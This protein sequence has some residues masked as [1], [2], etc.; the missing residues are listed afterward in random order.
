MTA[1]LS[2][3][4]RFWPHL[5]AFA[6]GAWVAAAVQEIRIE[7]LQDRHTAYVNQQEAL[8]LESAKAALL[9]EKAWIKEKEDAQNAAAQREASL[10]AELSRTR[11]AAD[12]LRDTANAI[13]IGLPHATVEAARTAADAFAAV[14]TDCQ[15]RYVEVAEKADRHWS[16]YREL[17]EAWPR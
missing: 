12:G 11:R 14:F 1:L 17:S 7:R 2:L 8:V 5:I 10:K 15:R 16:D 9:K 13:R 3:L 4:S 6:L